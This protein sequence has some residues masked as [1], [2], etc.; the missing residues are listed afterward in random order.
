MHLSSGVLQGGGTGP[1]IFRVAYDQCIEEWKW[2][3]LI[4]WRSRTMDPFMSLTL[5]HTLMTWSALPAAKAWRSFRTTRLF[6]PKFWERLLQPRVETECQER[7]D[8]ITL[9][10]QRL[11]LWSSAGFLWELAWISAQAHGKV[12]GS[13]CPRQW[14]LASGTAEAHCLCQIRF[15]TV[16]PFLSAE[17]GSTTAKDYG[18]QVCGQRVFAICAWSSAS[19]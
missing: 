15:C 19:L 5:Q 18:V 9:Q 3:M 6:T 1:R 4:P 10:W 13:T 14:Q 17:P 7:W 12:F 2:G 8:F 16:C 11:I